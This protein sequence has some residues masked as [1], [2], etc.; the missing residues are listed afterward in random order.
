MCTFLAEV[1][2][3]F[4]S[5]LQFSCVHILNIFGMFLVFSLSG[6]MDFQIPCFPRVMETLSTVNIQ[7]GERLT[8]RKYSSRMLTDRAVTRMNCEPVAMGPI[9]DRMTDACKTLPSSEVGKKAD[10]QKENML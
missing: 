9:V 3:L 6:I 1:Y 7:K 10:R 5:T 4:F 8:T 2:K